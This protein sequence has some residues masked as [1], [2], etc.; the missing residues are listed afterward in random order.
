MTIILLTISGII[1]SWGQ[2]QE[3]AGNYELNGVLLNT[4]WGLYNIMALSGVVVAALWKPD[5]TPLPEY[6]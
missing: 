1:Y 3:N 4:F 6:V 2:L 5:D